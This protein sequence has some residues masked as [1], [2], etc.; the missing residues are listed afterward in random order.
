VFAARQRGAKVWAGVRGKYREDAAKLGVDGVVALEDDAEIAGLPALDGIANTVVGD[1]VQKLIGKLKAGGKIGSAVGEPT[2]AK[3]RGFVVKAIL[4]HD[5][6]K[7]LGEL[8]QAVADG[9]LIV[10]IAKRFPL[11][12]AS[13]AHELA[14]MGATGKVVLVP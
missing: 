2:D 8:A 14:E 7:R 4:T 1:A 5:D 12:E 9:E 10:P 11:A 13:A 6:S 3:Q